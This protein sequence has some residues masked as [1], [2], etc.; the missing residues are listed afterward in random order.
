[1]E[2]HSFSGLHIPNL[3][4][5]SRYMRITIILLIF[6]VII[7][8]KPNNHQIQTQT[9]LEIYQSTLDSIYQSHPE[10]VGLMVHIESPKNGISWS[11]SS[12]YSDV[13]NKTV[14]SP[15]Q[16]ALIAS[17]IKTYISA[18]IL[19]LQEN[20]L[21][22]IEDPIDKYLTP[23]T[24]TL[25]QQ[26]GYDFSNIK[27][28]HLLSHTS[29]IEDYATKEYLDWVDEN[30]KHRWT[31]DKQLELAV[32][33]GNP[34][35]KPEDLFSYADA[36]YLLCT[37]IIEQ[38]SKK[39][40][41]ESIR[42]LLKYKA[43]NFSNTW[44]PTLEDKHESPYPLVH[45]YWKEKNWDSYEHDISWDLYGGGGIA[46]TTEELAKFS[47]QLFNK[48]I[49]QDEKI[50]DLIYSK[51][52]TKD[53]KNIKYFLGLSE[54]D[55]NGL[56][57]YGHGGFWG[58]VVM[59]YPALDASISVFVLDRNERKLRKDILEAMVQQLSDQVLEKME[60]KST[61]DYDLYHSKTSKKTL[62]LFPGGA[63]TAKHIR[64][65]FNIL[66][67]A[68]FSDISVLMMNF[69]KHLWIDET[70]TES[71]AK[72]LE[73]ALSENQLND[74]EVYIG[75]MSMGG[76]VS[77]SLSNYLH[78]KQSPIAPK[79]T[80]IIDSPIDLNALYEN[81]VKDISNPD[82]D[83]Q[84][85]AEPKWIVNYFQKSFG[86]DSLLENIQKVSPFTLATNTINITHLKNQ[87]LRFYTEPDAQWWMENRGTEFENTNAFTIQKIANRL[88]T[89]GWENFELIETSTRGVR[90]NGDRHPHS[91]SIVEIHKLIKWMEK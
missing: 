89:E 72:V 17:S 68:A 14:L 2:N 32:K 24:V 62:V 23:K 70:Q 36:N 46:T 65:D 91:W 11:G 25:F 41:Y 35:G 49:I 69:N 30:Q 1:M 28:K 54:G 61:P 7:G 77:L 4:K 34:L 53:G 75:G 40:F 12:G 64:E 37:E 26:D 47:Y 45:Q 38:V 57:G 90:V 10:S 3:S 20:N 59:Y 80:F 60:E 21:L 85:L 15:N 22:N 29:G 27:I 56:T 66:P 51:I 81:S 84:R 73:Q 55:T 19:R 8:C 86:K 76:N 78:K 52:N 83:E 6:A 63:A 43:L 33:V 9:N 82:F 13:E 79:G 44:F 39:P 74:N 71:L 50:F 5:Y 58:T 31:R 42:E 18:T 48:N 67:A 88:N 87:N 16:P